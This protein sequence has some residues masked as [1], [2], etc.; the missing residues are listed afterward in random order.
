MQIMTKGVVKLRFDLR[1]TTMARGRDEGREEK[2]RDGLRVTEG[3]IQKVQDKLQAAQDDLLVARDELQ[4]AQA[5]SGMS[6]NR[7]RMS[8]G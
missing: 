4:A 6:C 5:E 2:A 3:E 1:H 8:C 7:P